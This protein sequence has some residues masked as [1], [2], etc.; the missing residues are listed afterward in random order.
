MIFADIPAGESVFVDANPFIFY[1]SSDPVFGPAC[2]MLLRRIENQEIIG[3]TSAHVL[4][5]VAHRL[6][7]SEA[8][9]T[10]G[11]PMTGISNRLKR[12]PTQVQTLGRHRQ[13]LDEVALIGIPV[14]PATGPEVSVAADRSC[15]YGLL[16]SDALVL[17]IM[18][19]HALTQL[20]SHD[21]DFDRVP[22]ITRY[23]PV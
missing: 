7:T 19:H 20:A 5:E 9:R 6:M 4:S 16:S 21:A 8:S 23:A 12:H 18:E 10:F 15:Q 14:L 11:W 2:D 13:A 1:F 22:G 3:F 17:A